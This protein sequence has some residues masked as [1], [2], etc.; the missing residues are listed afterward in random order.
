M[1]IS[2]ILH[3]GYLFES[4]ATTI[5][6]DPIFEN[7]FSR[8]CFA[9]P[10]ISFDS[11]QIQQI[12]L[13]A[14]FIS[15]VHDDHF[16]LESLDLLDRRTPIYL[17]SPDSSLLSLISEL[18]FK[19]VFSLKTDVSIRIG[20]FCVTPR[21]AL[22]PDVDSIYEIEAEGLRVLN[23]VDSWIDPVTIES[24]KAH[25][26][27]DLLLWPFQTLRELE[28]LSPMRSQP[29]AV[30]I[31][32]E[33]IE[34]IQILKPR[35]VVPSSCQFV[36]EN[37]SWYNQAL[38]PVSYRAFA[39]QV[40]GAVP[41]CQV[42]RMEPA[43][44]FILNKVSLVPCKSLPW[45]HRLAARDTDQDYDY[46]PL[47]VVP[48]TSEIAQRFAPLN[49]IETQ[50]V[51]DYC[52]NGLLVKFKAA[53]EANDPYFDK[54]CH[55]RLSIF[56]HLGHQTDFNYELKGAAI[57]QVETSDQPLGWLTEIPIAKL[58]AALVSGESLT[59]MYVRINDCRFDPRIE[60]SIGT[61]DV[62]DDPLVRCLFNGVSGAYQIAQLERLKALK[63]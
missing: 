14:A 25:A 53:G 41:G 29:A 31:P 59:S 50:R 58:S 7:P 4:G 10:S 21:L 17:Y 18:G 19:E 28:V 38:F 39:S 62:L 8:N 6:F 34:Q 22:D 16:S 45:I 30:G 55:W 44:T 57:K 23:V 54:P 48:S 5:V 60:A 49:E 35:F 2:R 63:N 51:F 32:S 13:A 9:F 15:H 20:T 24:L 12:E 27:W 1:K 33:W 43:T 11:K 37:W 46:Q 36:H 42:Q 26:P 52:K 47:R 56:N 61:A 40:Q 3:A